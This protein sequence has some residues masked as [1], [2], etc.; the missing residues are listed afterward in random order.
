MTAEMSTTLPGN[1]GFILWVYAA[2]GD[3]AAWI[4]CLNGIASAIFDLALYPTLC[5]SYYSAMSPDATDWDM[6]GLQFAIIVLS[7]LLNIRGVTVVSNVTALITVSLVIAFMVEFVVEFRAVVDGGQAW[8]EIPSFGHVQWGVFMSTMLWSY[9]GW[10]GMGSVAGEVK[11][12]GRA[13]PLAMLITI[14]MVT[15]M[16]ILP[17]LVAIQTNP[18]WQ[19]YDEG[20]LGEVAFGFGNWIGYW[21][22]VGAVLANANMYFVNLTGTARALWATGY[23]HHDQLISATP[24][25]SEK[26]KP[27]LQDD[28]SDSEHISRAVSDANIETNLISDPSEQPTIKSNLGRSKSVDA[29]DHE[30][31]D[32]LPDQYRIM[33]ECIAIEWKRYKTPVVALTIISLTMIGL[34]F[35]DFDVLVE[36]DVLL[37]SVKL[38]FEFAAF[39]W[40]RYKEPDRPRPFKVPGGWLGVALITIP[41]VSLLLF[42]LFSASWHSW[43]ML[44]GVNIFGVVFYVVTKKVKGRCQEQSEEAKTPLNKK[45][46]VRGYGGIGM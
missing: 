35:F 30:E 42:T 36:I 40:F 24:S 33:P 21:I 4:T 17:L 11:N 34:L 10:D 46:R 3:F 14:C 1:G 9:T 27:L 16:Y 31:E 25:R 28:A 23:R 5:A 19:D 41:K 20:T 7:Y 26:T 15:S 13:F 29:E 38:L 18:D 2:F 37:A 32:D 45:N 43:L 6:Y 8:A 39:L 22:G 12:V 44:G